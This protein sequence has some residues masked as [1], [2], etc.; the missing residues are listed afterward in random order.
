MNKGICQN[1]E[2]IGVEEKELDQENLNSNIEEI[3]TDENNLFEIFENYSSISFVADKN[4]INF[5]VEILEE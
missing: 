3:C 4:K 5:V 1:H 2:N